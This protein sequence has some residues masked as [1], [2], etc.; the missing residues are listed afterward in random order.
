[1]WVQESSWSQRTPFKNGKKL[2]SKLDRNSELVLL[3]MLCTQQQTDSQEAQSQVAREIVEEGGADVVAAGHAG[4][5]ID[6]ILEEGF[7]ISAM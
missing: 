5:I 7:E 6:A 1:M 4:K 2:Q 3:E